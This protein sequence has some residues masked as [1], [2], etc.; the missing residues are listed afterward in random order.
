MTDHSDLVAR[1]RT[2][3]PLEGVGPITRE[4]RE[5]IHEAAALIETQAAEIERLRG[6]SVCE[7]IDLTGMTHG[8]REQVIAVLAGRNAEVE[9]LR[10]ELHAAIHQAQEWRAK[11]TEREAEIEQLEDDLCDKNNTYHNAWQDARIEND[12]LKEQR[13]ALA[14]QAAE[15]EGKY[16]IVTEQVATATKALEAVEYCTHTH[17]T[18]RW[19]VEGM[20]IIRGEVVQA[21]S[22]IASGAYRETP[23]D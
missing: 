11:L 3:W 18:A 22:A 23:N 17:A 6:A 21:L 2:T 5:R 19:A 20:D 13:D 12:R 9:R 1:L 7:G 15:W 4:Q 8:Q 14:L 10:A 16:A